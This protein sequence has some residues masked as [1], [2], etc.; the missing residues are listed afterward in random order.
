MCD[1][2]RR[3]PAPRSLTAEGGELTI[4]GV[5]ECSVSAPGQGGFYFVELK[6]RDGTEMHGL[7]ARSGLGFVSGISFTADPEVLQT[8][9]DS[10]FTC[11]ILFDGDPGKDENSWTANSV[12]DCSF[13]GFDYGIRATDKGY[14]GSVGGCSFDGCRNG[15]YLD[16]TQLNDA[17]AN[18]Q[19]DHNSFRNCSEA[20][21]TIGD[22]PLS[23]TY[24]RFRIL[25]NIFCNNTVDIRYLRRGSLFCYKNYFTDG[26][27]RRSARL[28]E[29]DGGCIIVNPCRKDQENMWDDNALLWIDNDPNL[30]N[31]ILNEEAD[32]MPIDPDSLDSVQLSIVEGADVRLVAVWE[33]GGKP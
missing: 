26:E 7:R 11:G 33:F 6:G 32:S 10:S 18:T 23:I 24:Y 9:G 16:C 22:L 31:Q 5:V 17:A 29:P 15:L 27:D 30:H 1:I 21:V 25:N 8:Y 12:H 2:D 28:D 13:T 3:L 4:S 19:V 20:G 14:C